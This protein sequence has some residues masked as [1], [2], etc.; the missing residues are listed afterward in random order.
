MQYNTAKAAVTYVVTAPGPNLCRSE[1]VTYNC[2]YLRKIKARS[3]TGA[4]NNAKVASHPTGLNFKTS[5][6]NN[7]EPTHAQ[8]IKTTIPFWISCSSSLSLIS[9]SDRTLINLRN[10]R[11][12]RPKKAVPTS[13][14]KAFVKCYH[15]VLSL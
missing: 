13:H 3:R 7:A 2:T 14:S 10:R 6:S 8:E 1:Y 15:I 9:S 5:R 4:M 11:E 12:A